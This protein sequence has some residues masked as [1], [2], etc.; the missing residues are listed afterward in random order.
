MLR[1]LE[2]QISQHWPILV[3]SALMVCL[4]L[5]LVVQMGPISDDHALLW[6]VRNDRT[7]LE[8]MLAQFRNNARPLESFALQGEYLLYDANAEFGQLYLLVLHVMNGLLLYVLLIRLQVDRWLS[9]A[10]VVFR[11]V[12]ALQSEAI[13][14]FAARVYLTSGILL[15]VALISAVSPHL[16]RRRQ[17]WWVSV[18][19]MAAILL[20][21]QIGTLAL[22]SGI[23]LWWW[24]RRGQ[25]L[26]RTVLVAWF[27][28]AATGS[29]VYLIS[30]LV[31]TPGRVPV[32]HDPFGMVRGTVGR[33]IGPT[34][35][36]SGLELL[37]D[38]TW[39]VVPLAGLVAI[40]SLACTYAKAPGSRDTN[41]ILLLCALSVTGAMAPLVVAWMPSR[42]F[43]HSTVWLSVA[44]GLVAVRFL[45][46]RS[47]PLMA[48]LTAASAICL[49]GNAR[50]YMEAHRYQEEYSSAFRLA[51]PS[52]PP[53]TERIV[54]R[55]MPTAVGNVQVFDDTWS[56]GAAL[57]NMYGI[58]DKTIE[59][60]SR[61][62]P[63][64]WPPETVE[65]TATWD[66]LKR[67]IE[68]WPGLHEKWRAVE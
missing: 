67:R 45:G 43:Y 34:S 58:K 16:G 61:A 52:L 19:L 28:G 23:G 4:L 27:M 50:N 56:L 65:F 14:W 46:R 39:L 41:H 44:V 38:Q 5:P 12:F 22:M 18:P 11:L 29:L 33:W 48:I 53:G 40:V 10:V 60:W 13:F 26:S 20:M 42:T 9:T 62:D 66:P 49:L 47:W 64:S 8:N 57:S 21:E 68:I 59:V 3:V 25:R 63:C 6:D 15:L 31:V 2:E 24:W 36:A 54:A 35:F 37:Q 32:W 55:G 51:V 30:R 7:L 17:L 1:A